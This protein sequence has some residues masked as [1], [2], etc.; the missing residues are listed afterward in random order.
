[1]KKNVIILLALFVSIP[2]FSQQQQQSR[3]FFRRQAQPVEVFKPVNELK[4]N[5]PLA[6]FGSYLE[7]SYERVFKEDLSF[8][9]SA[10]VGTGDRYILNYN[11]TPYFRWFF[12]G[13]RRSMEKFGAG[14]FLEANGSLFGIEREVVSGWNW[15]TENVFGAGI[16]MAIGWKYVSRNDWVM[17]LLLG[18]G[19]DFVN[20]G[21]YPR[22]GISIGRRF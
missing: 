21:A 22:M 6:I 14:L 19:R 18:G 16:G 5:L 11:L 8:G 15:R 9:F 3:N 20:D 17:E 10:G 12:G 13:N 7:V 1:M 2:I 4:L